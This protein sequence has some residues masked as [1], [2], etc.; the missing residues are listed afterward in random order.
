MRDLLNDA[1]AD[2]KAVRETAIANAKQALTETFQPTISRMISA[3]LSEEDD[4]EDDEVDVQ[5]EPVPAPVATD[6][7]PVAPVAT[8]EDPMLADPAPVSPDDEDD[9]ELEEI[10]R[11]LDGADD[12]DG[13][14]DDP[15]AEND[16][17]FE[18]DEF[19]M[20]DDSGEMDEDLEL[21]SLIR[22]L[23]GEDC[24][25]EDEF[26][27][28]AEQDYL[29]DPALRG[30]DIRG[31]NESRAVR[32]ENK[33]LKSRL[34]EA[35]NVVSYLKKTINEVNLLNAK[36]MYSAKVMRGHSINESQRYTVLQAFDRATSLREVKL[37]FSTIATN[38]KKE[39]AKTRSKVNESASRT[40]ISQKQKTNPEYSF[41]PRWKEL[42]G[43]DGK[44]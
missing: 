13:F 19:D 14:G 15:L 34:N 39:S 11:E 10:L 27:E 33:K 24:E 6:A 7:A 1:I 38:L 9:A 36:L 30:S 20:G 35:L 8:D 28:G 22:E 23:E 42:A 25:D 12:E 21:E 44:K 4:M 18:E 29:R 5:P 43:L 37:V 26:T 3:R 32:A 31:M 2:A 40:I 17:Q 16:F 41:V